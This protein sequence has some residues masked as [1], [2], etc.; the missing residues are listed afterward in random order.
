MQTEILPKCQVII[1]HIVFTGLFEVTWKGHDNK[2]NTDKSHVKQEKSSWLNEKV[3][4]PALFSSDTVNTQT[5]DH[6][7]ILTTTSQSENSDSFS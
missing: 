5:Q 4:P 3:I 6:N 1:S 2:Q 7:R